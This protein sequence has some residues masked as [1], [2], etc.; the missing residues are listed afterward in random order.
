MQEHLNDKY[1]R[2]KEI[3]ERCGSVLIAYSGGVDSAFLAKVAH[4]VLGKRALA[5]TSVSPSLPGSELA[6]AKEIAEAIGIAHRL[7]ETKE[8]DDPNF[9]ENTTRRCFF[10]KAELFQELFKMARSEGYRHVVY[11]ANIDDTG[12]F[13]PGAEAAKESGALA[14]LME[15]G[16]TKEEIRLMSKELGL[17]TWNKPSKACLS[18]RIPFG[19][20]I[21][22][23]KLQ[24]IEEAEEMLSQLGFQQFRVRHHGQIA[25]IEIQKE[26][27]EKMMKGKIRTRVID[28]V[29]KA[30]FKFI[31]LDLEGYRTGPFNPPSQNS[32]TKE[33]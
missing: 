26:E 13:R 20:R 28:A 33:T 19:E 32:E 6:E 10:C 11:G 30:G 16:L 12:D 8:M 21:S 22:E 24:Q 18:S 14:P 23:E 7:I 27:L 17:S 2:L 29:K 1:S 31:T 5:V 25:R 4:D 3:L 9:L 15:A